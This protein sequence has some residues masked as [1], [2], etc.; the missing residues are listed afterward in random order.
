M[1]NV[2]LMFFYDEAT[3][4]LVYIANDYFNVTRNYIVVPAFQPIIL[5][6]LVI[7]SSI[8]FQCNRREVLK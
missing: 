1:L 5:F 8:N 3:K 4:S 2:F 7:V 6:F